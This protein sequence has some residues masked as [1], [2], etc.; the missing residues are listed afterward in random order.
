MVVMMMMM[1]MTT[2]TM[3]M[4]IAGTIWGR[5]IYIIKWK[6][7]LRL[8]NRQDRLLSKLRFMTIHVF[9]DEK[10]SCAFVRVVSN[11]HTHRGAFISSNCLTLKTKGKHFSE[12]SVCTLATTQ[13][14]ILEDR[15]CQLYRSEDLK[16]RDTILIARKNLHFKWSKRQEKNRNTQRCNFV[17]FWNNMERGRPAFFRH[18]NPIFA[19]RFC[20]GG[21]MIRSSP[22]PIPDSSRTDHSHG[23]HRLQSFNTNEHC[24]NWML[25]IQ[26]SW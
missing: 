18:R 23:G 17:I 14:H 22:R 26:S 19:N 5:G 24:R 8:N 13:C 15:N 21:G 4:M 6:N 9:W 7:E 16:I 20:G 10:R 11:T 2:T 25:P 3:M 12:T 1:M